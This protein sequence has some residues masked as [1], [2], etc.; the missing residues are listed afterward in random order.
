MITASDQIDMMKSRITMP[1]GIQLMWFHMSTSEN[2]F[3][4]EAASPW[5]MAREAERCERGAEAAVAIWARITGIIPPE[6][7]AEVELDGPGR[8]ETLCEQ[9]R[10]IRFENRCDKNLWRSA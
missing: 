7:Y 4:E 2:E 10:R 6:F 9:A 8:R 3:A 1:F 5:N